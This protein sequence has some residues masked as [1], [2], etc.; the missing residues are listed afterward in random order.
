MKSTIKTIYI[1]FAVFMLLASCSR[2]KS[3]GIKDETEEVTIMFSA[4]TRGGEEEGDA[5]DRKVTSLRLLAYS[6]N[7]G[8]LYKNYKLN[9]PEVLDPQPIRILTG[10]YYFVLIANEGAGTDMETALESLTDGVSHISSLDALYFP[11]SAFGASLPIPMVSVC[12]EI[13]IVDDGKYIDTSQSNEIRQGVWSVQLERLGV[14]IDAQ[15]TFN[16]EHTPA[17]WEL[18][19]SKIPDR[20][21]LLP[22]EGTARNREVLRNTT[23]SY[24]S[25]SVGGSSQIRTW[26]RIIIPENVFDPPTAVANATVIGVRKSDQTKEYE[27]VIGMNP[28]TKDYTIP[29]NVWVDLEAVIHDRII[30]SPIIVSNWGQQQDAEIPLK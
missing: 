2:D 28:D 29:R 4:N 16:D 3:I 27:A 23:R 25:G 9:L 24:G 26:N 30:L 6:H 19:L 12:K 15:I 11:V 13:V 17:D 8:I 10:R 22:A 7:T 14:R 20:A 18:F 1:L 5:D 21:Y